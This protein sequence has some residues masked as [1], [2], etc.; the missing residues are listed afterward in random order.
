MGVALEIGI[1]PTVRHA[2]D[3][4]HVPVVVTDGRGGGNGDA[5]ERSPTALRFA[6]DA[7]LTTAEEFR[8]RA[9]PLAEA[10]PRP[11]RHGDGV[12]PAAEKW[13]TSTTAC[14]KWRG[15]SWGRL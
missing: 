8:L 10:G 13:S 12:R 4:G 9:R 15:A 14:A 7:L 11:R 6:G 3:L 5:A 2:A 1:E